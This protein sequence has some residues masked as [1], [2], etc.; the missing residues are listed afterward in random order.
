MLKVFNI[1]HHLINGFNVLLFVERQASSGY[2]LEVFR[3]LEARIE[4]RIQFKFE[5]CNIK[6]EDQ[7]QH[8][9]SHPIGW[10]SC[11]IS[12]FNVSWLMAEA[13]QSFFIIFSHSLCHLRVSR[14]LIE[15]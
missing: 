5:I 9:I 2:A 7:H 10:W 4:L 13:M 1:W 11:K 15:Q 6:S 12:K 8:S 14:K 3:I